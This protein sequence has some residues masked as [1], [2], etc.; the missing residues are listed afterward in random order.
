MAFH[1]FLYSRVPLTAFQ[2]CRISFLSG[3]VPF[4]QHVIVDKKYLLLVS[5]IIM[6]FLENIK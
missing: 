1:M 6:D 5:I 2:A 3:N 4:S